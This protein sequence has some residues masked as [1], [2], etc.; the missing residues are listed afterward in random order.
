M[1]IARFYSECAPHN[2]N[3]FNNAPR[4]DGANAVNITQVILFKSYL[5]TA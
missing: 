3:K 1:Q 2:L 4:A 5:V